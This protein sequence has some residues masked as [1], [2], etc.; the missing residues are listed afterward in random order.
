MTQM[1]GCEW[2]WTCSRPIIGSSFFKTHLFY[3]KARANENAGRESQHK[4]N[5]VVF[6][7]PHDVSQQQRKEEKK[8]LPQEFWN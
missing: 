4:P 8:M 5:N 2:R 1:K 3:Y 6:G 7:Y